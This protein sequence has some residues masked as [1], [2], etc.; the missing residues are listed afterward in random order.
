MPEISIIIPNYNHASF[1]TER[2]ESVLS[3]S[4]NDFELIILDDAS[5]DNSREIIEQYRQHPKLA[6][7][8]Y[9]GINS[10][11]PFRQWK[12]GI[13]LAK[14]DW[15][16]IAESDDTAQNNFLNIVWKL[17][18]E[19]PDASII[20]TD[21]N[22]IDVNKRFLS[23]D[24]FSQIKNPDLNTNKWSSNYTCIGKDELKESLGFVCTINNA[25]SAIMKKNIL[26][27]YIDE[28]AGFIYHGDW[29]CYLALALH[30]SIVYSAEAACS[31]RMHEDSLLNSK[32]DFKIIKKEYF[33][34]LLF[35]L[36]KPVEIPRR[37]LISFFTEQYLN[38]GLRNF[39]SIGS[40]Y[41]SMNF[42]VGL[43]VV[44][45]IIRLKITAKKIKK[46]FN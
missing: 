33:R 23:A 14:S 9:N 7:I 15:I 42:M 2:I 32:K 5:T 17:A 19:N 30:G 8:V 46:Y 26:I 36:K 11:S 28:A 13:D 10:Q 12:K 37:K 27:D 43:K 29:F 16:W 34:I 18:Q 40:T 31:V 35:L 41:L 21:A 45:N 3:Q 1:L 20:Y 39:F 24:K 38:L 44:L 22:I 6:H 4:F 25:S